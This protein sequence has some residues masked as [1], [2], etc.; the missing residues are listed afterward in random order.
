[1][2][3]VIRATEG[4]TQ[5]MITSQIAPEPYHSLRGTP[6]SVKGRAYTG[7]GDSSGYRSKIPS[8][9][10]TKDPSPLPITKPSSVP[11][12]SPTKDPSHVPK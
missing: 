2:L 5:E 11:S 9:N 1:M 10:P 3:G 7:F 6:R 8:D 4:G 12:E